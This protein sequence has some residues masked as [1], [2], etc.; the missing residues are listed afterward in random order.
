M[1]WRDED[2]LQT[3]KRGGIDKMSRSAVFTGLGMYVPE[4]ML[5][6]EDLE[7]ML[8]GILECIGRIAA[9]NEADILCD[10]FHQCTKK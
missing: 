2:S 6:N 3:A 5:T 1:K 10:L 7:K 8:Q 4:K 9:M